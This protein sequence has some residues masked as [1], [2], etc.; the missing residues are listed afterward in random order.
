MRKIL[1]CLYAAGV[2]AL[3]AAALEITLTIPPSRV[4]N[5]AEYLRRKYPEAP[6]TNAAQCAA[7]LRMA[8]RDLL[9]Q[10]EL[11]LRQAATNAYYDNAISGLMR[12]RQLERNESI[13]TE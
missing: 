12:A 7:G 5:V 10:D 8:L 3:S 6:V 2:A 4:G 1:V 13:A 11:A 9:I